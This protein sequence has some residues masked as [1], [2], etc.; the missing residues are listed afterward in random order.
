[1]GAGTGL[2]SRRLEPHVEKITAVDTSFGMLQKLSEAAPGIN[3]IHADILDYRTEKKF[4]GIVSSMTLHH[5]EDTVALMRHLYS[6]LDDGGFITLAD[7][8]PED[9]DFHEGGNEGVHHF[10]FD[11]TVLKKMA[12]RA[13]FERVTYDIVYTI[14]KDRG[15]CY[16]IFLM[17]AMK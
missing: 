9:G 2:L 12:E 17:T 14:E 8:A 5:I 16:D 13:G 11:E 7:L 1:V 4:D 6:M 10:G 3:T 15:R